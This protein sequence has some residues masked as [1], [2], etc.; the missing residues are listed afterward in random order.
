[1]ESQHHLYDGAVLKS[2]SSRPVESDE[3]IRC[4]NNFIEKEET[5]TRPLEIP[6]PA[7]YPHGIQ[8]I[9]IMA[10]VLMTQFL[11]SLDQVCYDMPHWYTARYTDKWAS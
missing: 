9:L 11:I 2:T 8:L 3:G 6:K 4:S 10:A 5:G 7:I 1:M